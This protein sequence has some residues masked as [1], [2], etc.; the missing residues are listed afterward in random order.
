MSHRSSGLTMLSVGLAIGALVALVIA[1]ESGKHMRKV[2]RRKLEH[3]RDAVEDL[4]D[5][6]SE[7]IDKSSN[8]ADKTIERVPPLR[9]VFER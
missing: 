1:P 2:F 3:A 9:R 7:W 6:A 4:A 8:L 5:Q